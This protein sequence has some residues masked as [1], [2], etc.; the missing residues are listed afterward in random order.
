LLLL[1]LLNRIVKSVLQHN[2]VTSRF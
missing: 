2:S 1:H